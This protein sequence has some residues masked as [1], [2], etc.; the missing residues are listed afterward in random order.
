MG[1]YEAVAGA[2]DRGMRPMERLIFRKLRRHIFPRV[3]GHVL[4]L[5]AGTGVNLPLY[6]RG[7]RVVALDRSGEM[8]TWAARRRP[9][10]RVALV[11]AD[12]QR[13]P[14]ADGVFD[15]VSGALIFCSVAS[16]DRGLAESRRVLQAAGRLVL[17]EHMRG[18]GLGA[19]LTGLVQPLWGIWSRECR[20]DRETVGAVARAGFHV[21]HVDHH[22]LGI[23]RSIDAR[24]SG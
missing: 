21:L 23:V 5:G 17:L 14:F 4:E 20:L 10:A 19:I 7:A 15:A 18:R 1:E 8:L 13:L 6:E 12:A 3:R 16:P 22:L 11:Q 9:Q 2:Y 24:V